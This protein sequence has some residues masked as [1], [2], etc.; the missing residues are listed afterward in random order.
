MEGPPVRSSVYDPSPLMVYAEGLT[1]LL[2]KTEILARL[3][4]IKETKCKHSIR[5]SSNV[6]LHE[7][8][9]LCASNILTFGEANLF[10]FTTIT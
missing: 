5:Y 6:I 7:L 4:K 2:G 8:T 3:D 1:R 9:E 10:S